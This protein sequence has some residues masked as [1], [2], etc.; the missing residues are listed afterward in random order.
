MGNGFTNEYNGKLTFED[1]LAYWDQSGSKYLL[2]KA[3]GL[4]L[5]TSVDGRESGNVDMVLETVQI[6]LN[7]LKLGFESV[8]CCIL[9]NVADQNVLS[10]E[11]I[12][13][14]FG[15]P[16]MTLIEGIRKLEQVDTTKYNSNKENYIGLLV[17]LS[18]DIRV[19]LIR[20]AMRLY[21]VRHLSKY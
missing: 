5:N 6:I 19:L 17:T 1:L 16:V 4:M 14:E 2:R 20:L 3:F 21:D 18:D 8:M 9:K 12:E 15:K 10:H 11:I 13:K 7:D